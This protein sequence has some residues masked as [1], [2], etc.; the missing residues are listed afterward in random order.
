MDGRT[1]NVKEQTTDAE[2]QKGIRRVA[3][4]MPEVLAF[5]KI[6]VV[7]GYQGKA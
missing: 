7:F 3:E 6:T 5:E 2:A 1:T 4:A